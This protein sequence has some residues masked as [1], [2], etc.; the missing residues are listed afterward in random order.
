MIFAALDA[1][2]QTPRA[3]REALLGASDAAIAERLVALVQ[4][5]RGFDHHAIA[6][7]ASLPIG[8]VIASPFALRAV[9]LGVEVG[10]TTMH[11]ELRLR[12]DWPAVF[13]VD[14]VRDPDHGAW[15][16]GVLKTGKYQGFLA[17]EPFA[18][19]DPSHHSKWGPHELLHRAARFFHRADASRWEIYLGARLNELVPVVAWYGP[20]QVMR[21]DEREFD[22]KAGA[23]P[24]R[25][26]DARWLTDD[27]DALR[28]RA[29]SCAPILRAGIEHFERELAAIDRELAHGMRVRAPHA[30][31][32][33]S[34]DATAYAVGH[35]ARLEAI[36]EALEALLPEE[37]YF[38][39]VGA[40]RDFVEALFDRLLF[41]PITLD[42]ARASS[43][44]AGH[45]V[46]DFVHRAA[47][48]GEDVGDLVGDARRDIAAAERGEAIDVEAWRSRVAELE[49][50]ALLDGREPAL[51]QLAQ[52]IESFAPC[53]YARFDEDALASLAASDAL[54][55]RAPLARRMMAGTDDPALRDLLVLEDAIATARRDDAIEHLFAR[56][57]PDDLE[58][59][60]IVRSDAF[61][62]LAFEYDVVEVHAAFSEGEHRELSRIPSTWLVGGSFDEVSV[63]PC[64]SAISA[65]WDHLAES[66]RRPSD[67]VALL[68][69]ELPDELP[70]GFPEDAEG[71]LRELL[72][73]GAIGW[74]PR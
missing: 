67:L 73:A 2:A 20:E 21:L 47:H 48:F 70:E 38:R 34:S 40:Y 23:R 61:V 37:L 72:A 68:E 32:D 7:A 55:D 36:G 12:P 3:R 45:R 59:G 26:A 11:H 30:F 35:G 54:R 5:L 49:P 9:A 56:E 58:R 19:F 14:E 16:R 52:G 13:E 43:R 27:D 62:R 39:D 50:R 74:T 4:G 71:W 46:W 25:A 65:L 31:L 64:P 28:A 29:L 1:P 15:D 60:W 66:R 33:A 18:T 24:A 17:D 53:T 22:R 8:E 69:R 51:E 44:R 42:L 6:E 41:A 57:L 10:A 63:V